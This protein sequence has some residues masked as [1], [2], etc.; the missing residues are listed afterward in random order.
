MHRRGR[1]SC[2]GHIFVRCCWLCFQGSRLEFTNLL[3]IKVISM[4]YLRKMVTF[5]GHVK[6][7]GAS[8]VHVLQDHLECFFYMVYLKLHVIDFELYISRFSRRSCVNDAGF[9]ASNCHSGF[10]AVVFCSDPGDQQATIGEYWRPM[11]CHGKIPN[12]N[13]FTFFLI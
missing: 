6:A 2:N 9:Q 13:G 11:G 4:F 3:W 1:V 5:Y 8:S 12:Y 7:P 10:N